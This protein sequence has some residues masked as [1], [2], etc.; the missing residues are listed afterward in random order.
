LGIE[1]YYGARQLQGGASAT[2]APVAV[3]PQADNIQATRASLDYLATRL[4]VFQLDQGRWPKKLDELAQ[5][6]TNYPSGFL[7]GKALPADA[8]KHAFVYELAADGA[9]YRLWSL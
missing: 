3:D 2:A 5:A 6:T 1:G 9:H 4:A 8:W 7:D